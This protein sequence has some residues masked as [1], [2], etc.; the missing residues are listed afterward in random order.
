MYL[1]IQTN[2]EIFYKMHFMGKDKNYILKILFWIY[3]KFI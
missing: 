3:A 1:N 2:G